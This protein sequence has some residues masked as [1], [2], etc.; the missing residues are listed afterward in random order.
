MTIID[1]RVGLAAALQAQAAVLRPQGRSPTN[2]AAGEARAAASTLA[3]ADRIRSIPADDPQRRS[4]ALRMFLESELL[5][6]F[7]ADLVNDPL[8]AAMVD[9]V[10][11]QMRQDPVI[12]QAADA[13]ADVLLA[14]GA[15]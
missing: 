9:A 3:L 4:R 11:Q 14:G 8:F 12:A 13:L 7:G 5:R 2:A 1:P 15:R 10:H 6:E